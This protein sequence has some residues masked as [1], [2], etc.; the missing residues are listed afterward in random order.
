MTAEEY[1]AFL[2]RL[3]QEFPAEAFLIIRYGDHQ[4]QFGPRLIDPS[5]GKEELAK[6]ARA[7]DPRYLTTY[8]AL[9]A[10]NFTPVD[11]TSA[12]DLLDAPYLPLVALQ[13]AGIP[14]RADFAEQ[15]AILQR[16]D[17]LFYGCEGGAAGQPPEPAFDR[18]GTDQG[19][20][21]SRACACTG[22]RTKP[23]CDRS[24]RKYASIPGVEKANRF[25]CPG[26]RKR[27]HLSC[28]SADW[29]RNGPL[30][31]RAVWRAPGARRGGRRRVPARQNICCGPAPAC[32][33]RW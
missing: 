6:R 14:L 2:K 8:Y 25:H 4:P 23:L 28:K 26:G 15:K 7:L 32:S 27:R 20:L 9:D 5:L 29:P 19:A 21:G 18:C 1:R 33:G 16:C 31:I 24:L 13:A 30:E 3:A 11:T 10:V 12:L 17:G 22:Q